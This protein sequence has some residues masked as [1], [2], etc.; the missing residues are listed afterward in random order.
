MSARLEIGTPTR[1]TSPSASRRVRVVAHLGRQV[2]GDRQ[3]GLALLEEVAE[4]AVGLLGGREAGVLAHRPEPAAVHRRLDAAG[5]R[6]LARAARGRAPRRGRPCRPAVYRSRMTIPDEVSNGSRRSG[7]PF[8]ALARTVS[9]QRSRPGSGPSPVGR[10]GSR[11][12]M[13][14]RGSPSSTVCP[15][16]TATRSTVPSRGARSSFSI[17]IASTARSRW[18]ASTVVAGHD[19]HRHD[20]SR[21]DGTN[22]GRSVVRRCAARPAV[23]RSR[24]SARSAS[25]TSTSN[26]QPSTTTSRPRRPRAAG[27]VDGFE[28][29]RLARSVDGAGRGVSAT[30]TSAR[31]S[32]V[33]PV[34]D[35][36][37]G[38]CRPPVD[39]VDPGGGS[40][41]FGDEAARR[42]GRLA[43]RRRR[44]RPGR[45]RPQAAA[46]SAAAG[47]R[48][49]LGRPRRPTPP[50]PSR[51]TGRRR[52]SPGGGPR[53]DG[54]AG[55]SGSRRSRSRRGRGAGGRWPRPG[56]RRGP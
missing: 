29:E 7:A 43:G 34:G 25:S 6:V 17:F 24:R 27:G 42:V 45:S 23:A 35:P 50:R 39:G 2:E 16:A 48:T 20:A 54:T 19:G 38:S 53:T 14:T 32:P 37:G 30:S 3:P 33:A 10:S 36:H 8:S 11:H 28:D 4:A 12:R 56:P 26:R 41:A 52:E 18:P 21:D 31:R 15:T 9:R 49:G 44:A 5:E 40:P 47:R 13:T 55:S 22:L 1:P 46:A 51:S